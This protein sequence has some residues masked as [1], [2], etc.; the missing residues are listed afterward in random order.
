MLLIKL[1]SKLQDALMSSLPWE[2][3]KD[4]PGTIGTGMG[5]EEGWRKKE[6]EEGK[7]EDEEEEKRKKKKKE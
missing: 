6:E 1:Y 5:M 3:L 4:S 2:F 7:E